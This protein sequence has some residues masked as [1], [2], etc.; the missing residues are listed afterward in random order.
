MEK[1]TEKQKRFI[2]E[3][4][5]DLNATQAAIRAGYSEKTA[6]SVGA[7]NLIKPYIAA[8]VKKAMEEREKRTEITQDRVL[9]ELACIAFSSGADFARVVSS[10]E[11]IGT[12]DENGELVEKT[13]MFQSVILKD[14]DSLPPDKRAAI[15]C[16]KETKNGIVVESCDKVKALELL[17]KHL[18]MF[19]DGLNIPITINNPYAGLTEEELRRLANETDTERDPYPG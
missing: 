9:K 1:M 5:I 13:A 18:G 7:E 3:Y 4:L 2:A 10:E 19:K 12:L 14:T 8:E 16:I 17:G 11:K 15:A 6:A